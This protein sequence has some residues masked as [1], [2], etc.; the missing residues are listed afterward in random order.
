MA[1]ASMRTRVLRPHRR[2][3]ALAALMVMGAASSIAPAVSA[4]PPSPPPPAQ[5]SEFTAQTLVELPECEQST[6][7]PSDDDAFGPAPL[8]FTI[9]FFGVEFDSVWVSNNGYLSFGPEPVFDF[10]L[11]SRGI[12]DF[13]SPVIAPFFADVD[14]RAGGTVSLGSGTFPNTG[15]GLDG[16]PYFCAIWRDVGYY[17]QRVDRRNT[18]QVLLVDL[19]AFEGFGAFAILFAYDQIQW[20]AGEASGGVNGL[21]GASARVGYSNGTGRPDQSFELPGSA[22][23]GSFLDSAASGLVN[24]GLNSPFRGVFEFLVYEGVPQAP[25]YTDLVADGRITTSYAD[26]IAIGQFDIATGFADGTFGPRLPVRRDQ[27]TKFLVNMLLADGTPLPPPS[28]PPS[29]SDIAGNVHRIT[30]E[31]A[32]AAG[33]AS[34]RPDGTFD[35]S[36]R[37]TRGQMASFIARAC[38]LPPAP[39]GSATFPDIAGS[40]HEDSIRRAA[41]AG[42]VTGGP[43]GRFAPNDSVT[44]GQTARFIARA[45]NLSPPGIPDVAVPPC[46]R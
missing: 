19:S 35:P 39:S 2:R 29:F 41:A 38:Q 25:S 11:S 26:I 4:E 22:L 24:N 32:A 36:G 12:R 13:G 1:D 34:G 33:I 7:A 46:R 45:I 3:V 37:V 40:V 44:R 6:L 9:D 43:D 27:V 17:D 8:G 30:I 20:E 5:G 16:A 42:I 14:S 31:Q 23:P 28:G 10:D 18:F 15:D 21:G